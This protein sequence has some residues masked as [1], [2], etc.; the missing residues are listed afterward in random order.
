MLMQTWISTIPRKNGTPDSIF[1]TGGFVK[2]WK[3]CVLKLF[4]LSGLTLCGATPCWDFTP[5]TALVQRLRILHPP[6]HV[7]KR[8]HPRRPPFAIFA[9]FAGHSVSYRFTCSTMPFPPPPANPPKS[10]SFLR[11][12]HIIR[13]IPAITTTNRQPIKPSVVPPSPPSLP[14]PLRFSLWAPL[15]AN[16]R[17]PTLSTVGFKFG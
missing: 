14:S 4:G 15:P 17:L 6:Y 16:S 12:H 11:H 13:F 5:G 10:P 1:Q 9:G 8:P 3:N 2:P 7:K